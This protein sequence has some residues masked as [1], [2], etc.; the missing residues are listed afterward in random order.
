[1]GCIPPIPVP[2]ILHAASLLPVSWAAPELSGE[3]RPPLDAWVVAPGRVPGWRLAERVPRFEFPAVPPAGLAAALDLLESLAEWAGLLSGVPVT[4]GRLWKSIRAYREREELLDLFGAQ[5]AEGEPSTPC[6][7]AAD[8]SR[9][10]DYLPPESH[11]LLLA[12]FLGVPYLYGRPSPEGEGDREEPLLRLARR[13][14]AA[15]P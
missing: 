8:L 3:I 2:E 14:A 5:R 12:D 13:I 6:G 4:E 7:S 9:A 15:N 11:S 1:M 10:G